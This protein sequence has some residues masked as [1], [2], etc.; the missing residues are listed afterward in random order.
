MNSLFISHQCLS[1]NVF[2]VQNACEQRHQ[3][4]HQLSYNKNIISLIRQFNKHKLSRLPKAVYDLQNP[5]QMP[6]SVKGCDIEKVWIL[7]VDI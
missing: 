6:H 5:T 3:I 4:Y 7:L 2:F 1:L